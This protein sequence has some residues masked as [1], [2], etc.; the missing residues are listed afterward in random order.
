M[1]KIGNVLCFG[2]LGFFAV[3]GFVSL[4]KYLKDKQYEEEYD[5]YHR[6]FTNIPKKN[7]THGIEYL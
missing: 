1:K 7:D 6:H 4:K 2:I 5:D 3:L